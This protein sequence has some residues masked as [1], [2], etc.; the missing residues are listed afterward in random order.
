MVRET[1]P[2]ERVKFGFIFSACHGIG[3]GLGGG[4]AGLLT[5]LVPN[6]MLGKLQIT[7][8]CITQVALLLILLPSTIVFCFR[9]RDPSSA[10]VDKAEKVNHPPIK[11]SA[12]DDGFE[13]SQHRAIVELP[14]D[15]ET[16]TAIQQRIDADTQKL[17][18]ETREARRQLAKRYF[19]NDQ[20]QFLAA[21]L[22]FTFLIL[23]S[24]IIEAPFYLVEATNLKPSIIGLS[25]FALLA[26]LPFSAGAFAWMP[27]D[28]MSASKSLKLCSA[29]LLVGLLLRL[30]VT[31]MVYPATLFLVLQLPILAASLFSMGLCLCLLNELAS[32]VQIDKSFGSG[33]IRTMVADWGRVGAGLLITISAAIVAD[34][35]QFTPDFIYPVALAALAYLYIWLGRVESKL[36]H[37]K[38]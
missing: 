14:L 1:E 23:E 37:S 36:D 18:R 35:F 30:Q 12:P 9:F 22:C 38:L 11:A 20:V 29:F 19:A 5:S 31:P 7:E 3:L 10:L 21:Y 15:L 17:K 4:L 6:Y 28:K 27:R 8:Y 24:I 2:E 13:L 25:C 16:Q 33:F 26:I 32:D 34:R